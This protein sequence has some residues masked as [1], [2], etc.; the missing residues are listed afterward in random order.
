MSK[1]LVANISKEI[2]NQFNMDYSFLSDEDMSKK[3][4]DIVNKNNLNESKL[5]I[6]TPFVYM[7][8]FS[9]D[10]MNQITAF[11]KKHQI[12]PIYAASTPTNLHWTLAD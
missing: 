4:E 8:A 11:M 2:M 5:S 3:M 6:D 1:C 7:F 9:E 12:H 10:E